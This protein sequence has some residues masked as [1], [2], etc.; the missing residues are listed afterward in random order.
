MAILAQRLPLNVPGRYYVD[1]QC[2]YCD[3]CVE[4][5]PEVF[6]HYSG[7]DWLHVAFV[8]HQ[9]TTETEEAKALEAMEGC[10]TESIG[11]V[12]DEPSM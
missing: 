9:P 5:A 3:L 8:F 4:T 10:P 7:E 6:K 12:P 1:A 2:I 11:K